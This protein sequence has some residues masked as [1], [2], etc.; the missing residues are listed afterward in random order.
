M[1][2]T[3]QTA[4]Y[5]RNVVSVDNDNDIIIRQAGTPTNIRIESRISFDLFFDFYTGYNPR[6]VDGKL[7][8]FKS[9]SRESFSI[10]DGTVLLRPK[11]N[12]TPLEIAKITVT[13]VNDYGD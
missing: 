8:Y 12:F 13:M 6:V 4:I 9:S 10:I 3:P 2:K 11:E 1:V 5:R 7:T